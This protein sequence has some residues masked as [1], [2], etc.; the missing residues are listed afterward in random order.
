MSCLCK[1]ALHGSILH[2]DSP[3][4]LH[5]SYQYVGRINRTN[6]KNKQTFLEFRAIFLQTATKHFLAMNKT[7][8]LEL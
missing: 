4:N 3:G 1:V 8:Y 6:E 7:I 5:K 2:L